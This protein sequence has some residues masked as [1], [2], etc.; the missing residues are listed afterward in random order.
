M[1]CLQATAIRVGVSPSFTAKRV[2]KLSAHSCRI[3]VGLCVRTSMICNI[4]VGWEEFMAAD[5]RFLGADGRALYGRISNK[6]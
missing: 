2:D 5:G 6:Q 3:G 1:G 4:T